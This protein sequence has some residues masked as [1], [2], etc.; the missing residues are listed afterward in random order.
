MTALSVRSSA[1]AICAI[2]LSLSGC[3]A[4]GGT[5][6]PDIPS[7]EKAIEEQIGMPVT[8]ECPADIPLQK[9]KI[10][11]CTVTDGTVTKYVRLTQDD[12]EGHF[13]WEV[14]TQDAD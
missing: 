2:S 9:G 12:A 3:A 1:A 6:I 14:T 8:I 5:F 10:T 4:L 11:D 13:T 7:M